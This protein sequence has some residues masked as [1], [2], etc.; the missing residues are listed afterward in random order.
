MGHYNIGEWTD[1][2][3]GLVSEPLRQQMEHH[4]LE[5]CQECRGMTAFLQQV[6]GLAESEMTYNQAGAT[7]SGAA[8]SVFG[9]TTG[10]PSRRRIASTLETL[11]ARLTFDNAGHLQPAGVRGHRPL[12]RQ[13]LFEAG[14]YSIDLRLDRERESMKVI[15]VGQVASQKDPLLQLARLPVFVMEGKKVV[16]ETASNQFGEFSLEFVP[17]RNLR[18]CV[19]VTQAG[20]QLEVPLRRTLE[21]HET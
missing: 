7:L 4:L 8:R 11:L 10:E 20:L 12:S 2:V 14:D 17:R 19:Q 15:L 18:L 5:N 1:F 16:S 6:S 9:H 21:E 3:R 13:L